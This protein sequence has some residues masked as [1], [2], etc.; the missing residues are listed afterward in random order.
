MW[1]EVQ[2][3]GAGDVEMRSWHGKQGTEQ[4]VHT[5]K[6]Q[7]TPGLQLGLIASIAAPFLGASAVAGWSCDGLEPAKP[8]G[9][10][11][12]CARRRSPSSSPRLPAQFIAASCIG[13]QHRALPDAE[14]STT[15]TSLSFTVLRI[16]PAMQPAALPFAPGAASSRF[17]KLCARILQPSSRRHQ[18]SNTY[19]RTR[20]RLNIKPDPNFLPS[21]T[22]LHDH[23]IHNPPPSMPNVYHT[24]NIF[25]PKNDERKV[26]PDPERRALQLQAAQQLP[27]ATRQVEKRYHL[28]EKDLHEMRTLRKA[29]PTQWSVSKLSKKFDCSPVFTHLVVDGLAPEKAVEQKA[30]TDMIR[31]N[32]GKKRKEAREDR[33]IRKEQWLRDA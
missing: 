8:Y 10:L 33:E 7:G 1:A 30:V 9:Y 13:L 16:P 31:S 3:T 4:C 27:P 5:F 18:S 26:R 14:D 15:S 19:R 11:T 12:G 21:K 17:Y 22:E 29:D 6:F 28:T 20:A 2:V 25:L 32:W 24:P 23:I